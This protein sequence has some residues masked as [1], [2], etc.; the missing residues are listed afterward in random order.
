MS[1]LVLGIGNFRYD[2]V[3]NVNTYAPD[4]AANS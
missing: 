2:R 1:F 3:V 4:N